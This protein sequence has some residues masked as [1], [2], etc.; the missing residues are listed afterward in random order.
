[1]TWLSLQHWIHWEAAA[2]KEQEK[3]KCH[4][5]AKLAHRRWTDKVC[6]G[7]NEEDNFQRIAILRGFGPKYFVIFYM[8]AI[9][10]NQITCTCTLSLGTQISTQAMTSVST[11]YG[12]SQ[13][14]EQRQRPNQD[15]LSHSSCKTST[16]WSI[17]STL[18]SVV[19]DLPRTWDTKA[20]DCREDAKN[21]QHRS[22]R[23]RSSSSCRT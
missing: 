22:W 7:L 19:V 11:G 6:I 3:K 8:S 21:L 9:Y 17:Y 5:S 16:N 12:W 2:K 10:R 18:C 1:M 4:R 23:W 15:K 20:R 13:Q 14:T